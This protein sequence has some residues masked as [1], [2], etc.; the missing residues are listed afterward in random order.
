[1]K[2]QEDDLLDMEVIKEDSL[3]EYQLTLPDRI[4]VLIKALGTMVLIPQFETDQTTF[5]KENTGVVQHPI[6][7][8]EKRDRALNVLVELI[9]QL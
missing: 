7:E 1:M 6:L 9:E 2:E 5:K 8:G 3:S 4:E